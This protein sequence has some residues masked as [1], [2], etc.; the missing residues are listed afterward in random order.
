M[1]LLLLMLWL[2]YQQDRIARDTALMGNANSNAG[3]WHAAA[4]FAAASDAVAV[5]VVA[6]AAAAAASDAADAADVR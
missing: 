3:Y 6:V 5:A 2:P 4:D 1:S